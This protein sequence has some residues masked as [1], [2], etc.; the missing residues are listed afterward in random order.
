MRCQGAVRADAG[1][2]HCCSRRLRTGDGSGG[3]R[4]CGGAFGRTASA[5]THRGIFT[6]EIDRPTRFIK[7]SE[8][9]MPTAQANRCAAEVPRDSVRR[10]L[11]LAE[12]VLDASLPSVHPCLH[13]HWDLG[14]AGDPAHHID[15]ATRR[16]G[17][18]AVDLGLIGGPAYCLLCCILPICSCVDDSNGYRTAG[19][20]F[21]RTHSKGY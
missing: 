12:R 4:V 8:Q 21:T 2:Y 7:N 14:F 15:V 16:E 3:I 17:H 6:F 5:R 11:A 10:E 19:L 18:R 13:T 20:G 9:V 1:A